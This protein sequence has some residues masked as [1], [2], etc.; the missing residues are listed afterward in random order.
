LLYVS[1][2]VKGR[3]DREEHGFSHAETVVI[4]S[5]ACATQVAP[6]RGICSSAPSRELPTGTI[7]VKIAPQWTSNVQPPGLIDRYP[8]IQILSIAELLTGK[9]IE[10]PRLLED[11]RP[12]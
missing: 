10:Y 9:K 7:R 11:E 2:R 6:S 3:Q 4:P 8:R 5:E 1:S 12:F